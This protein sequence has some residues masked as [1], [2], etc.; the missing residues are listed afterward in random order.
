VHSRNLQKRRSAHIRL[1]SSGG[2]CWAQ[3]YSINI[4]Y[5]RLAI[6][7][8]PMSALGRASWHWRP[9]QECHSFLDVS[10]QTQMRTGWPGRARHRDCNSR[11]IGSR[12]G[13][14]N[15]GSPSVAFR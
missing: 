15:V 5:R 6:C 9:F 7:T 11:C 14:A 13:Y 8:R 1:D 12:T 3:A 2:R 10:L 4:K